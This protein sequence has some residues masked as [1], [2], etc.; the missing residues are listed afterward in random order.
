LTKDA[1]CQAGIAEYLLIELANRE[2][3][4]EIQ[5]YLQNI[6]G[7]RTVSTPKTS[8]YFFDTHLRDIGMGLCKYKI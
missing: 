4:G 1:L 3:C 5:D 7:G 8:I 6:T 2:D